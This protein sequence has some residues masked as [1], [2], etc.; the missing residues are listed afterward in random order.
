VLFTLREFDQA[1]G[2]AHTDLIQREIARMKKDQLRHHMGRGY[3][4]MRP[5][6]VVARLREYARWIHQKRH[7]Y[8]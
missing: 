7:L 5:Q 8:E 3:A 4:L 2:F 1:T 6:Y